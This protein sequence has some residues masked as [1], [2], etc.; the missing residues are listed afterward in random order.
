MS[1]SNRFVDNQDGTLTDTQTTLRWLREDGWQREAKWF[2]W[3]DAKDLYIYMNDIKFCGFQDW[4]L[5]NED[6]IL[7]LYNPEEINKDKYG[8]DIYLETVFPPGC[9]ATVWL[10]GES[11]HEGT[12]FD[13]KNGETRPLYKS[14]TGRMSVRLVRGDIPR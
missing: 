6:E 11:G 2:S 12:I 10:N 5:P 8:N 7:T 1:D 4:K 9:Q 13:F 14:K 3:D